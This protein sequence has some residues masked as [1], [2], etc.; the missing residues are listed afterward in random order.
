MMAWI[1][2]IEDSIIDHDVSFEWCG[3]G[4]PQSLMKFRAANHKIT[5]MCW[6][7]KRPVIDCGY[8]VYNPQALIM[9][10]LN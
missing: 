6:I 2:S 4:N 9:I 8:T 1:E 10:I 7:K 3:F 5:Q